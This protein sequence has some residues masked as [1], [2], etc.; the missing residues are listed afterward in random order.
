MRRLTDITFYVGLALLAAATARSFGGRFG[1][2]FLG[3]RWDWLWWPTVVAGGVLIFL[4]FLP[5]VGQAARRAN[6]R[7]LRYGANAVV[8]VVLVLAIAGLVEAFS[9]RHNARADLTGNRRHSLAPQT[10]QLLKDLK[11]KV[12][13]VAFYRTDQPGKRIIEDLFK[14][15]ARYAG[16]KFTWKVVDPDL[17]PAVTRA[18][19]VENYGTTVLEAK[20]RTE[21]VQ[22]ADQ[23]EKL[24]NALLKVTREGK[25]VVYVVQG[26][27]ESDLGT[28]ERS[29]FSEAKAAME[30][31]NYEVKPLV[32][33]RQGKVPD[34]AA[35]VVVPGP[36]TDFLAPETDAL[37]AYLGRGGKLL[38]MLNPPFPEKTQ[39]DSLKKLLAGYGF[40]LDDDVVIELNPVGQ[41][42]GTG[43]MV[44]IVQQYE[45]HPITRDMTNLMTGF[46]VTRSV[47]AAKTLPAGVTVQPLAK[48]TPDSWGETDLTAL[49]QR[50][51]KPDPEDPKGPLTL[52]A[53][54]TK[55]KSR[56]VLYGSAT[57]ATNQFFNFQ[58]NR[59]FVL[60]SVSWLAEEEDQISIRPRETKQSPVF[61][62]SQQGQ[63][64]FWVPVVILPALA[65]V[66]G[67]VTVGRRRSA[68]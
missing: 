26:H 36:R 19:G 66:G 12:N 13:A 20:G 41:L 9:Y 15:Y 11:T 7:N 1:W 49:A 31:A 52:A 21:K 4:S 43:A 51:V 45:P 44:P 48:T 59:D 18:L 33:A 8:V 64:V 32:L 50:Q 16:D 68:K 60:N 40:T 63:F 61:L 5:P 10:I 17:E 14:Q 47:G 37:H 57:L 55:D 38:A 28:T 34:D 30:K 39:P 24:T 6:Q 2:S 23:E 56:I 53:V 58:G 29:G 46:P 3:A 42:L 67:V 65:L 62:T 35:V 25:R 54:A 27:G 22:D